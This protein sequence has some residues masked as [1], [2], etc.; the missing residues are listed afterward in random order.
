MNSV[1]APFWLALQ[2]LTRVP[3]PAQ[4]PRPE[5]LGR[6]VLAY[7]LVGLILGLVLVLVGIGLSAIPGAPVLLVAALVLTFWVAL[8]GALHLDGLADTVDAWVGGQRHPERAQ[9]I[10]KDPA[11]GP[12]AVAALILIL[13]LKG[14]ALVAVVETG[15]WVALL[16]AVLLG[17]VVPPVL[18]LT[19][20]YVNPV[21]LGADMARHLPRSAA[22][23]VV[24]VSAAVVLVL[25]LLSG[26]WGVIPALLAA[27]LTLWAATRVLRH[28]L[29]GFTGDTAGAT[30]ELVETLTL[31]ILVLALA[32]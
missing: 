22:I 31:V 6:S 13:L 15:A 5:D 28:W 21:G 27:G 12:M 23:G 25:G 30:L 8:T 7:P 10:M 17:R 9:A 16:L 14:T 11:C 24:A 20:P 29:G 26:L 2:F 18:F 3:T 19:T 4:E 32:G 1:F